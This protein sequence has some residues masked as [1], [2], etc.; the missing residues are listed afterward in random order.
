ML[1]KKMLGNSLIHNVEVKML[2]KLNQKLVQELQNNGRKSYTELGKMLG[3]T[4]GTVRKRVKDLQKGNVIKIAA[5]LNPYEI[6][7]NLVSIMAIQVRMA[8]LHQVGE[9]LAQNPNIYYLAFV[10]GRYD[11]LAMIICRSP[12]ELSDFI[13]EHISSIP[14]IIRTETFVNLEVIKSPWTGTWEINR[15]MGDS[16]GM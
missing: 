8:D 7:Y 10:T 4:E 1:G 11:L 5:V 3:V 6:G 14:S 2:D 15:L 9:T 12:E 13:K 16:E